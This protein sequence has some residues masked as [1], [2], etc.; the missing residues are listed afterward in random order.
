MVLEGFNLL[1]GIFV[2]LMG[3]P[4]GN[5]LAKWTKE[6]LKFGQLWF[7]LLIIFSLIG[8][9]VSLFLKNDILFFSFLFISIVTSRSL[10]SKKNSKKSSYFTQT[11]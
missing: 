6:E 3:I 10:K 1:I 2:V 4:I 5:L 9:I 11:L 7:K 8:S